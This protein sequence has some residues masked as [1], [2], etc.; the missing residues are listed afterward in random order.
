MNTSD[1]VLVTVQATAGG[2]F[3]LSQLPYGQYSC[4]GRDPVSGASSATTQ[5]SITSAAP[6]RADLPVQTPLTSETLPR[7]GGHTLT[8]AALGITLLLAGAGAIRISQSR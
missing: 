5:V 4:N 6:A 3:S 8:L 1:D 7:T 2:S